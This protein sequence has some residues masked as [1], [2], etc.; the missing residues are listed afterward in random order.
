MRLQQQGFTYV[1]L[2]IVV[3]VIGAGLAS[4]GVAWQNFGQREKE[5]E[6]LFI[7]EEF[8]EALALYYLRS[9]GQ[10]QEYPKSLEDLISDTRFGGT[11][12]Y[13]R[14]V[15]RDP[16]TGKAEWGL[17]L[18]PS[19]RIMGIHSLSREMPMKTENFKAMNREFSGSKTYS[20]WRF[21]FI[22]PATLLTPGLATPR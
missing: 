10:V 15:Y 13:L 2:L 6:L 22:P 11:Q 7:G 14:K 9:P 18:T 5:A 17:V 4:K 8:R 21:V 20:D 1:A 3:A 16:M 19:G 12:R